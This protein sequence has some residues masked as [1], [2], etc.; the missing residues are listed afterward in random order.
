MAETRPD[1]KPCSHSAA[2]H[3]P[4]RDGTRGGS[5]P[6]RG[7][8]KVAV[9]DQPPLATKG[10]DGQL[11]RAWPWIFGR[12]SA[13]RSSSTMNM[14]RCPGKCGGPASPGRSGHFPGRTGRLGRT[15]APDR[16]YP[17]VFGHH[18]G[19]GVF[20]ERASVLL[21]P[22]LSGI[23]HHGLTPVVVVMMGTLFVFSFSSGA[24]SAGSTVPI[25]AASQSTVSARP[26][27]FLRSP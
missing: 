4:D 18:G 23:T 10:D 5:P 9:F 8:L 16:F 7:K 26:C 11:D 15:G 24:S 1:A 25:S 20:P 2:P 21:A 14:S 6:V 12:T 27:G 22:I 17:A 19:G 3:R 13:A